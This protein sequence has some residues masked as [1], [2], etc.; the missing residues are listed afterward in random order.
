MR[1]YS[2]NEG[3]E[4]SEIKKIRFEEVVWRDIL[5][6]QQMLLSAPII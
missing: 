6:F 2:S 3:G 5:I 4:I 1:S